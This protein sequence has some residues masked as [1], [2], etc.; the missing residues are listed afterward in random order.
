[1]HRQACGDRLWT[2]SDAELQASPNDRSAQRLDLERRPSSKLGPSTIA[3]A[4]ATPRPA[5]DAIHGVAGNGTPSASAIAAISRMRGEEPAALELARS[6]PMPE[7]ASAVTP[8]T[9]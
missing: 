4:G 5:D 1:M 7:R 2:V 6:G 3:I 9:R 8:P